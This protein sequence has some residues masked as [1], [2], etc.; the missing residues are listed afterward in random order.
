[1]S[2]WAFRNEYG[3]H[4]CDGDEE[5]AAELARQARR[6]FDDGPRGAMSVCAA[7]RI[8]DGFVI[9]AKGRDI[10]PVDMLFRVAEDPSV[11]DGMLAEWAAQTVDG[12]RGNAPEAALY[13]A[14]EFAEGE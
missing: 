2:A 12:L 9:W 6:L 4:I 10:G 3:A 13:D 8:Q 7:N 11:L 5:F 1:M 14:F